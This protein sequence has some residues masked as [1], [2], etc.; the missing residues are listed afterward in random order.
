ML[1]I[2]NEKENGQQFEMNDRKNITSH[3][4]Q[5]LTNIISFT[6]SKCHNN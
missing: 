1:E 6:G 4:E 5:Y 2:Q 3:S